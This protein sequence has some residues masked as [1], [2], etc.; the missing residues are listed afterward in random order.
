MTRSVAAKRWVLPFCAAALIAQWARI[1]RLP[2]FCAPLLLRNPLKLFCRVCP[3]P[4]FTSLLA[5]YSRR[6]FY[7]RRLHKNIR[8]ALLSKYLACNFSSQ[9]ALKKQI[10]TT[11]I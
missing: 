2:L 8:N 3:P 5:N 6:S 10:K 11:T 4:I 1:A 7:F 9:Q